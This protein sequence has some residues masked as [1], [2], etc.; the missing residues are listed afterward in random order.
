[1]SGF[2]VQ[3]SF[4]APGTSLCGLTWDG[5]YLW[6]S[7]GT[8][9][10]IYRLD[11]LT[12]ETLGR[13]DCAQVR[14]ELVYEG[15]VLWQIAGQPKRIVKIDPESGNR[16]DSMDLG[17]KVEHICG[18][19]VDDQRFWLS[20]KDTGDIEARSKYTGEREVMYNVG[21]PADGIVVLNDTIWYTSYSNRVLGAFDR[22]TKDIVA[23]E[24]IAGKPT[25]ICW[26]G[27]LIWYC[28]YERNQI[29]AVQVTGD[30][31]SI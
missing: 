31:E 5:S 6:H 14:T 12:G 13:V 23:R 2:L 16:I 26:D 30:I 18:L 11:P 21:E 7:D 17:I 4:Q 1:M 27:D 20:Q 25:G 19:D 15:G 24:Q 10:L 3:R 9:D 29:N 8:T 28:D 22:T